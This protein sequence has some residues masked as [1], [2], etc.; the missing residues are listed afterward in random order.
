MTTAAGSTNQ[1]ACRASLA[2]SAT[3]RMKAPD[4]GP[5]TASTR[6]H[7]LGQPERDDADHH[8]RQ[9]VAQAAAL[10]LD[11]RQRL[12]GRGRELPDAPGRPSSVR[13]VEGVAITGCDRG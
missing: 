8:Q 1:A 9:R 6:V 7:Q 12:V 10:G 3:R 11:A 2:N 4:V 13:N 5:A